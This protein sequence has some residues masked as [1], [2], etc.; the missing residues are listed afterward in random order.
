MSAIKQ[1]LLTIKNETCINKKTD[2]LK[3]YLLELMC[4]LVIERERREKKKKPFSVIQELFVKWY[5]KI[6]FTTDTVT[7]CLRTTKTGKTSTRI[8]TNFTRLG[9]SK[10]SFSV[11]TY[12]LYIELKNNLAHCARAC[13]HTCFL[14]VH[15]VWQTTGY[16]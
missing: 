4:K 12:V 8:I 6:T 3:C 16:I 2:D 13:M 11:M 14:Y 5:L 9:H 15:F 7:F 1:N 10:M